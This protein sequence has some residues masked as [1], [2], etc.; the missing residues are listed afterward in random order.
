MS[1]PSL[2]AAEVVLKLERINCPLCGSSDSSVVM[3]LKDNLC[4]L[5]GEFHL[6][7]CHDC[8]HRFMNPRPVPESLADCYPQQYGPHQT[9]PKVTASPANYDSSSDASHTTTDSGRPLYLRIL[10][11]RYVPGL[12]Q[13]YNWLMDDRSQPVPIAPKQ[14]EKPQALELGCATGIYLVRLQEAGW[15]ATG[16]EPGER[17]ASIAK[18]AGL[19]VHCG[20]L[21][22]TELPE[23]YFQL[24]VAWMVIEHVP[25][26]RDT[27]RRLHSLLQ[28]GGTLLFS[29]PNAGCWE[30][31]F[32]GSNWYVWELPRHLHHFT[33]SSIRRLLQECG[34]TEITITHQRNLSNVI[35]SLA[36][37]ILARWPKSAI[38]RWLLQYPD[39]PTLALKLFLAPFA[40]GLAWMRQ[41]GRLTISARRG[42]VENR[43]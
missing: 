36:I 4:G 31:C 6:E 21:E 24:A 5:P 34:F 12:K 43:Q 10:S 35:G 30:T 32:F 19:D 15:R 16:I 39:Q 25:D 8:G 14:A 18:T 22:S 26:A 9:A 17:P 2:P 20:L 13:F 11:L 27:L 42:N 29:V 33:P 1:E 23:E 7:R 28:P 40:H 41:G 38:G 3:V 37:S